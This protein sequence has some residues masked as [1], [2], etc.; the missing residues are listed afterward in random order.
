MNTMP[1]WFEKREHAR[2]P[3][4]NDNLEVDLLIVGGG[5]TGVTAAYLLAGEGVSVALLE[6]E[7]LGGRDTGH[8]TAHLT[9]MTDTRLSELVATF[10]RREAGLA[11]DAGRDAMDFISKT[12]ADHGIECHLKTVT[13]YLAAATGAD[14]NQEATLLQQEA[15][16]ARQMGFESRFMDSDPVTHQPCIRF[17]NQMEFHP[18][19]YLDALARLAVDRGA[20][21]FE[22]TSVSEFPEAGT[23]KAGSFTIKYK[24]AF[25]ATHVPLQGDSNIAGAALFQ[26][27]MALYS[28]YAIKADLS[29]ASPSD[30]IWSDTADPFLYLRVQGDGS[31][32]SCILGGED[33][34]TGQELH[35]ADRYEALEIQLSRIVPGAAVTDRWSGQVVETV[36]GLPFIG[37]TSDDQFIATGFSGNGMTLGTA[38]ALMLRDWIMGGDRPWEKSF[39][40][41]RNSAS[42]LGEYLRENKDYAVRMITDRLHVEEGDPESIRPGEGKVI[43]Y[44][45]KRVAAARGRDGTLSIC[46]AVCPHLGCI[47]AWNEAESTWDCPCHGS[48]FEAGG[49]VIAGPAEKDLEAL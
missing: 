37:P 38:S 16:L 13:G 20:R 29:G 28:T 23:A 18:L 10:S 41:S 22:G 46:S 32:R 4:L 26:T 34:K 19:L 7:T 11:W 6:R 14:V 21:I 5:I 15:L 9:Y 12:V 17:E 49:K 36:D 42:S 25:I 43:E 45:G 44:E 35:P 33:H 1:F 27:K 48:R 24:R 3:A 40:P 39:D 31:D 8:T 47:V 2:H 30:M